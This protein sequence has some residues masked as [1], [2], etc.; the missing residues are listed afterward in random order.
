MY[1]IFNFILR[2][3]RPVLNWDQDPA[4][5]PNVK[6]MTGPGTFSAQHC[7]AKDQQDSWNQAQAKEFWN[8][9]CKLEYSLIRQ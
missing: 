1:A 9:K 7:M 2:F 3:F 6:K 8:Q 5:D 4:V